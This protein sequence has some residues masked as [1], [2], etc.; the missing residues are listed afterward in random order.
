M[1]ADFKIPSRNLHTLNKNFENLSKKN[2]ANFPVQEVFHGLRNR[3]RPVQHCADG[4]ELL[5]PMARSLHAGC[6]ARRSRRHW[7]CLWQRKKA[8]PAAPPIPWPA[9]RRT[10]R[11]RRLSSRRRAPVCGSP[12]P[13][14]RSKRP[15]ARRGTGLSLFRP[16]R[17]VVEAHRLRAHLSLSHED[18]M[19]MAYCILETET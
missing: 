3:L 6:S 8:R 10:L 13:S 4:K 9:R 7:A 11:P 16:E 5:V 15:P 19:A 12:S 14:A 1:N 2:G 17:P 18:G